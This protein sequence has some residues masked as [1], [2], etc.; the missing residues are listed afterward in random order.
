MIA[1]T[2][3]TTAKPV[4]RRNG[5]TAALAEARQAGLLDGEPTERIR[6]RAPKALVEAAKRESG[7]A[8]TVELGLLGLAMLAQPDPTSPPLQKDPG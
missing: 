6:F 5:P 2:R 4:T 1:R 8:D 3:P 7:A